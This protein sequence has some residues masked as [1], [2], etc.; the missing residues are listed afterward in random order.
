MV[1]AKDYTVISPYRYWPIQ[2]MVNKFKILIVDDKVE[3]LIALE[4]LLA[5][6][7]LEFIRASSGNEA[8][9]KTLE[10][11]FTLA[12]IDV[13]MPE[14]DGY[15]TVEL[16]RQDD[17]SKLL[18]I[19]FVSAIYKNDYYQIKGIETGAVDFITK[20][21]IPEI[22]LG[23]VR[24][25]LDLYRHRK[26]LEEKNKQL[27]IASRTDPL[28]G[29][30]NRRDVIDK[31]KYE[32]VRCQRNN[33]K[34]CIIMGDIDNFKKINDSYGHAYGD[35]VL[36]KVSEL[37]NKTLRNQD[38]ISRWGGEEFF[39]ILPE[40]DLEDG[41]YVAEKVR[42]EVES[43]DFYINRHNTKVTM[44]F[45]VSIYDTKMSLNDCIQKADERLYKAKEHGRNRV[46]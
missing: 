23:K 2:T 31:I 6:L 29:L 36:M 35:Q 26:E 44:S 21:I 3:N 20:P 43:L 45:G 41:K 15:E 30:S 10:Y 4:R 34:F 1:I 13:Q 8:L 14:M 17:K 46:L 12:L 27:E 5:D 38:I 42:R 22:L 24:V 32:A 7:D 37:F 11:E 40:T 18:P 28:T 33:R 9:A 39:F 16:L 19:I 25:F